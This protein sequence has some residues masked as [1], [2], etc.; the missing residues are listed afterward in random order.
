MLTFRVPHFASFGKRHKTEC[1]RY[2][3][4][5]LGLC[6]K[7]PHLVGCGASAASWTP[8]ETCRGEEDGG[9]HM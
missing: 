4:A 7:A 6:K 8:Q 1:R 5:S 9:L 2:A 3:A